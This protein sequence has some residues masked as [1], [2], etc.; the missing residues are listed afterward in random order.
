M[1]RGRESE[2][3]SSGRKQRLSNEAR[4][5]L[6]NSGRASLR[7]RELARR[8]LR[9]DCCAAHQEFRAA[10]F[11]ILLGQV[12]ADPAHIPHADFPILA[13]R[14]E[15]SLNLGRPL[16]LD[17]LSSHHP[18][19]SVFPFEAWSSQEGR[20]GAKG[21]L[22]CVPVKGVQLR[23]QVPQVPEGHRLVR[24]SRRD[25]VLVEGVEMHAVNFGRVR[26]DLRDT[27]RSRPCKLSPKRPFAH[28]ARDQARGC[29]RQR[30]TIT[31]TV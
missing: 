29:E 31:K 3:C 17:H 28:V 23:R 25:Q 12:I 15:E 27:T 13:A 18:L 5:R 20:A 9:H 7:V 2:R 30:Q 4:Q 22:I 21:Y 11:G 1:Q 26:L 14:P 19:T 24:A 16:H 6:S 10:I 8:T